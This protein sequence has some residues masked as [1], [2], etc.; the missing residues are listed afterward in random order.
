MHFKYS[1]YIYMCMYVCVYI[2]IYTL[3]IFLFI[4]LFCLLGPHSW[5]M[6]VPWLGVQLKLQLLAYATATARQIRAMSA[7]HTT[8]DSNAGSLTH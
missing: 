8:A 1:K 2:S 3:P 4:Y 6:E 7:T 5:H